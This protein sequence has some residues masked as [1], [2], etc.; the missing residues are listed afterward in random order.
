MKHLLFPLAFATLALS[1]AGCSAEVKVDIDPDGDGLSDAEEAELGVDPANPD[2][3]EDGY[4][5]GAE[6][7]G[8]TNP[9]D[10]SDHPYAG[11][12]KIDA[13]RDDI[14][15]TGNTAGEV[16]NDFSLL[17]QHGDQV[18]LHSF[19]DQVVYMVFAAFW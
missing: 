15:P 11:G 12:W 16:A 13:C 9:L 19:C 5:D 3:D 8:N 4:Q 18:T 1:G 17:D 14:Q 7:A 10:Q 2:S 6:L